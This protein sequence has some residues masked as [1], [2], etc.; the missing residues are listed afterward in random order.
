MHTRRRGISQMMGVGLCMPAMSLPNCSRFARTCLVLSVLEIISTSVLVGIVMM[1]LGSLEEEKNLRQEGW[2]LAVP[3][4]VNVPRILI[5]CL[6]AR[7]IAH[8]MGRPEAEFD[9]LFLKLDMLPIWWCFITSIGVFQYY[10]TQSLQWRSDP[11]SVGILAAFS[12][13]NLFCAGGWLSFIK[14]QHRTPP[15]PPLN[16][17]LNSHHGQLRLSSDES[18]L[19]CLSDF[20]DSDVI[21][22]LPCGHSFHRGCIEE[23]LAVRPQCPLR[24]MHKQNGPSGRGRGSRPSRRGR[25]CCFW[26]SGT[27]NAPGGGDLESAETLDARGSCSSQPMSP[28]EVRADV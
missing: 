10:A 22:Q 23:W 7:R 1:G 20:K 2:H 19:V 3:I 25:A 21:A 8:R 6:A 12:A 11:L 27:R 14:A 18:C 17:F 28:R 26:A 24:C 13:M 9:R 15:P 4:M 16:I 5:C